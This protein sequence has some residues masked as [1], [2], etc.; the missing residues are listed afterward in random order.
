MITISRPVTYAAAVLTLAGCLALSLPASAASLKTSTSKASATPASMSMANRVETRIKTLHD[1]L[2]ISSDQE[3]DWGKVA[4]AMRANETSFKAMVDERESNSSG[5]TA[6]DDLKSYQNLMQAYADNAQKVLDA[7]E[8][9]Y[10]SMSDGQKKEADALFITYEGHGMK[11]A[12]H[13]VKATKP[14]AAPAPA[15]AQ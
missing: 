13:K 7:F 12:M 14:A 6:V 3:E 11:K 15:A 9:L 1:K 10:D 8:P 5:M 2:K 4:A